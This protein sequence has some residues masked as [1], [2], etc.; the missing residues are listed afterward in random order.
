M[1]RYH[2]VCRQW[3]GRQRGAGLALALLAAALPVCAQQE[4]PVLLGGRPLENAIAGRDLALRLRAEAQ[5]SD[6]QTDL[7]D[8]D[9]R[10]AQY[11]S[12]IYATEAK[13]FHSS[14]LS[15]A[16]NYEYWQNKDNLDVYRAGGTLSI[17]FLQTWRTDLKYLYYDQKNYPDLQY[18]S[19]G[20]GGSIGQVFTFTQY[21]YSM[22]QRSTDGNQVYQYLSWLPDRSLR[23]GGYG[24]YYRRVEDDYTSWYI[25]GF[26]HKLFWED[27]TGV[28]LEAQRYKTNADYDFQEYRAYVYQRLWTRWLVR[29]G[30]RYYR[31][32]DGVDSH[33]CSFKVK[34]YIM[35]NLACHAEYAWFYQNEG[36]NINM[37]LGGLNL[38]L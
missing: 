31:D 1:N 15:L 34:C 27:R 18:Y 5:L 35:A 10:Y 2:S 14:R 4:E 7:I 21:R 12:Q 23:L 9:P 36:P 11:P 13:L 17:P 3:A 29:P 26:I 30:Y 19:A 33:S 22:A 28:R 24:A 8:I 20:V 16:G 32:D 6:D 37:V 25:K 38:I